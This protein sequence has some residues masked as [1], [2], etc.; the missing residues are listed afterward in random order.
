MSSSGLPVN[1]HA[2]VHVPH[3][4]TPHTIH[5]NTNNDK[6]DNN[7]KAIIISTMHFVSSVQVTDSCHLRADK[8]LGPI[9]KSCLFIGEL[10]GCG[11]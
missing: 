3:M 1:P 9:P 5:T 2:P 4:C 7:S 6:N 10:G 8:R 11:A